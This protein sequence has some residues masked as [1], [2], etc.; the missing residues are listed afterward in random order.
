MTPER[1]AVILGHIDAIV[2]KPWRGE[3]R[4]EQRAELRGFRAAL[5]RQGEANDAD[6]L[7]ALTRAEMDLA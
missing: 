5:A 6:V 1:R 7:I 4:E 3:G 2:R